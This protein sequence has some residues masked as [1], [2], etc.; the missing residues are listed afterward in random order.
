M[1]DELTS[2][3]N[4]HGLLQV[5]GLGLIWWIY[6]LWL[7]AMP[8]VVTHSLHVAYTLSP[9]QYASVMLSFFV[10]YVP[11]QL[12]T[13]LCIGRINVSRFRI[14]LL[15]ISVIGLWVMAVSQHFAWVLA[16][17]FCMG[18]GVSFVFVACLTRL[19]AIAPAGWITL[20]WG[21][22]LGASLLLT[23]LGYWGLGCLAHAYGWRLLVMGLA[24]LGIAV[25]IST[26]VWP[27]APYLSNTENSWKAALPSL[28]QYCFNPR[29][30]TLGI[31]GALLSLPMLLFEESWGA[32]FVRHLPAAQ[33]TSVSWLLGFNYLGLA[34][35][36]PCVGWWYDRTQQCQYVLS[37]SAVMITILLASI[38]YVP[39]LSLTML[40][41]FL[42]LLGF[43]SASVL[44]L[45][46]L[47]CRDAPRSHWP[48]V[49]GVVNG[50][51]VIGSVLI[52]LVGAVL[53][54][55]DQRLVA[56]LLDE[57]VLVHYQVALLVLPLGSLFAVVMTFY[58]KWKSPSAISS[59]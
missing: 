28:R 35:G 43:F 18:I 11:M 38:L 8:G 12:I 5:S 55:V 4:W 21:L 29:L 25:V 48:L 6:E 50:Y 51:T 24:A 3:K 37:I 23:G 30:I 16:A 26:H 42:A 9:W 33:D 49:I 41:T 59:V 19:A 47:S 7:R 15:L 58:H 27:A 44:V 56:D 10:G 13:G 40:A 14:A 1:K 54:W 22:G 39:D 34:I 20:S 52:G 32:D 31:L 36:A 57:H 53:Q 17:R 2:I 45:F 46:A